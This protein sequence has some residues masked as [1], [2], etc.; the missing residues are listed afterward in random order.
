MNRGGPMNRGNMSQGGGAPNMNRGG[1]GGGG[2]RGS[3]S[4][5][6]EGGREGRRTRSGVVDHR[7]LTIS[8]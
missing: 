1:G 8:S 2:N 3:F 6:S 4:Q 5:V 7:S